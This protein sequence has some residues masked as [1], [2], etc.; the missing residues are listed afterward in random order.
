MGLK[1]LVVSDTHG[2]YHNLNE[3]YYKNTDCDMYFHCGDS[4]IPKYL[5]N[6][7]A[8]VRGNCDF[9]DLPLELDI[10]TQYGIIHIEHGHHMFD[11]MEKLV[12]GKYLMVLYGH[13]H[14]KKADKIENTW[15]F[16]PGSLTRPRDSEKGSYLIIEIKDDGTINHEFKFIDL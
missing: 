7:F 14:Y 1:I 2:D 15:F 3:I 13:T 12:S 8:C 6:N 4:C 11:H 10:E 5:L 9:I 16:N